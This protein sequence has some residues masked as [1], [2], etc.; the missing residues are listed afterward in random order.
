MV[1]A[2]VAP[3]T[4][5]VL[6]LTLRSE[7][8]LMAASLYVLAV[9]ATAALGGSWA[10]IGASVVSFLA[11][12]FFFTPPRHTFVVA[13]AS[14]VA[15]LL[16]FLAV[17]VIVGT[18][19]ARVARQQA[20][21]V[22]REQEARLVNVLSSDLLS[23]LPIEEVLRR[24]ASSFRERSELAWVQISVDQNDPVLLVGSGESDADRPDAPEL[25]LPLEGTEGSWGLLAAGRRSGDRAFDRADVEAFATYARQ[26]T[27]G[28]E[29]VELDA[30]IRQATFD[31]ERNEAR[32]AL[33]S[34]VTHDLRTPL[35]SIMASVTSLLQE[36]VSYDDE[37]R[38]DLLTTVLEETDR[39]NRLVGNL[40]DLARIR[41]GA[42]TP[43]RQQVQLEDVIAAVIA[44]LRPALEGRVVRTMV[45]ADVPELMLDPVQ[46]DQVFTN[47]LE[48]AIRVSPPAGEIAISAARWRSSVQVRI[49][50]HGP[51]IRPEEREH[52]F[53]AFH[54]G[55]HA[56]GSGLG[57][58]IAQ[59]VVSVHGGRSWIEGAPGGGACVVIE[60]PIA[61]GDLSVTGSEVGR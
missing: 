2:L 55:E 10:G 34:S 25:T 57:L 28:L 1:I 60:L 29:R 5:T 61:P 43:A 40:L 53:E 45:R 54:R 4:A 41:V 56:G 8:S 48:N 38:R 59:A 52:V 11:L 30:R 39:L 27:L 19:V 23:G 13:S 12:N 20:E 46:M 49:S 14:D 36:D 17:S 35:A 16:V 26:I 22:R 51:G 50:D 58:S 47:I 6:A 7:G 9:V 42:L 31:A 18:L 37:Q 15:E 44:R 3:A 33:F 24:F 32:A 21:A